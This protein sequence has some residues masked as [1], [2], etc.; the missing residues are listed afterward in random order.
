MTETQV[1]DVGVVEMEWLSNQNSTA[2]HLETFSR[3]AESVF[4]LSLQQQQIT[5]DALGVHEV[6][7]TSSL[8]KQGPT[9]EVKQ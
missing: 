8:T 5:Q 2:A 7:L 9:L 1:I 6:A 3:N 4:I